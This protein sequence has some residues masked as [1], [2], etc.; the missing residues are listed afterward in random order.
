MVSARR[1]VLAPFSQILASWLGE[2]GGGG[3]GGGGGKR[4]AVAL[5]W[6]NGTHSDTIPREVP[7]N[8]QSHPNYGS[9]A[10]RVGS[11]ARLALK[12]CHTGC[13]HYHTWERSVMMSSRQV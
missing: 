9:L 5:T 10:S 1:G 8:W 2:G 4:L 6:C 12:C 13:I 7:C 3:G 11:L